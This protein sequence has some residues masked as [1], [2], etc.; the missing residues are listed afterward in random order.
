MAA[1]IGKRTKDGTLIRDDKDFVMALLREKHVATV[2]GAAY[3]MGSYFRISYA[4]D[5]AL[6]TEACQR[7][8]EFCSELR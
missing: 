1:H 5:V 3:G 4:A 8:V 2:Y 6:L 7:I